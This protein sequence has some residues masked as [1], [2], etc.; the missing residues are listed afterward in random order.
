MKQWQKVLL[1]W[2]ALI[3]LAVGLGL[4]VAWLPLEGSVKDIGILVIGAS[5]LIWT[6]Y[7]AMLA[8][9]TM[10]SDVNDDDETSAG[11]DVRQ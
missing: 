1:E 2:I 6:V 8:Y 10:W 3:A 5:L 11:L 9:R 4:G 7:V